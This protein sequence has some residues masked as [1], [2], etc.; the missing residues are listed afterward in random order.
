MNK[1]ESGKTYQ[2]RSIGDYDCVI[3]VT[4]ASR[5]AKTVKATVRGEVKTFRV[6]EYNGVEQFM[7][8]GNYSMAP[9]I[10]ADRVAA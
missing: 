8:W 5:T 6:N 9:R 4:I 7:P 3:K 10:T 1:F 2:T